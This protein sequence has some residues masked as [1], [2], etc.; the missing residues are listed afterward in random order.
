MAIRFLLDTNA[1][2]Y[3]T[4]GSL[5][6]NSL[7]DGEYGLSVITEIELL[8][9]S[10]LTIDEEK[11]IRTLIDSIERLPLSDI[12]RDGTIVLRRRNGL[13]LP[14]AVIAATA[15]DWGAVLLTNDSRMTNIA[16]LKTQTLTLK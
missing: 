14:D 3:L 8:S 5:A 6:T 2:I 4:G 10:A 16:G 15:I 7:P 12:V 9:F 13:K 11:A 1:A